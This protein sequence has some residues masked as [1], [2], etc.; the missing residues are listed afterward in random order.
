MVL[1]GWPAFHIVYFGIGFVK[2]MRYLLPAY[3]FL[4]LLA[5][6]LLVRIWNPGR[7]GGAGSV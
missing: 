4:V 7:R 3:P 1:V 6:A 2:T 5:A